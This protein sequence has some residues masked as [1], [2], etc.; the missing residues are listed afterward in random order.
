MSFRHTGSARVGQKLLSYL[1]TPD[2]QVDNGNP[3]FSMTDLVPSK[4]YQWSTKIDHHFN[5]AV[6][7]NGFVLRQVTHEASTNYNRVNDFVGAS[8]QL[9]RAINTFVLNNTYVLNSSTVLTLRGG[10]NHFDDNYN[11]NDRNGNH[12]NFN[13]SELGLADVVDESDARHAAIPHVDDHRLPRNRMDVTAGERLL[14]VRRQRHARA[15]SPA[16]TASRLAATTDK[17]ASRRLTTAHPRVP[18]RSAARSAGMRSQTCSLDTHRAAT[19]RSRS[20]WTAS[21]TTTPVTCRTTGA[22]VTG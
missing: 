6:A 12:L 10:Y 19:F 8:Y 14:P 1:Q 17:S 22:L 11:L 7:L 9:D 20:S 18:I 5:N 16:R 15:S 2:S 4:A 3:N 13:V 21:S